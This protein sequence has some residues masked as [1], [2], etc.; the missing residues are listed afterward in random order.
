MRVKN[1]KTPI[2][3]NIISF[4]I[5]KG[6][7]LPAIPTQ[8]NVLKIL[9]P[10][11]FPNVRSCSFFLA[12]TIDDASSGREVPTA[13]TVRP[14]TSSLTPKLAAIFTAPQTNIFELTTSNT[15]PININKIAFKI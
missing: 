8:A 2:S 11:I 12:E 4:E 10:I 1:I 13:T 6:I 9:E 5:E 7:M 15:N 3:L 14:I